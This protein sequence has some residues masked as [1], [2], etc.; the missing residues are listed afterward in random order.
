MFNI[1]NCTVLQKYH[2]KRFTLKLE[3]FNIWNNDM[4][5]KYHAKIFAAPN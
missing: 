1:L 3:I 5:Q 2:T 4:Q